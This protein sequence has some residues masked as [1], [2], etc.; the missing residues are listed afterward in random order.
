MPA[1]RCCGEPFASQGNTEEYH[2][3]AKYNIDRLMGYKY[4]IAH[5]PSCILAFREYAK[6]FARAKDTV[7][8]RE[9]SGPE[10]ESH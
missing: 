10:F 5:C 9:G 8:E 1:Q 7:Y 3:L 2:R 6:D 4:V